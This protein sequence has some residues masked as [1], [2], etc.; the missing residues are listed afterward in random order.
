MGYSGV[1]PRRG[2]EGDPEHLVLIVVF[3]G[4]D[5]GAGFFVFK[6]PGVGAYFRYPFLLDEAVA[7]VVHY[8]L[9]RVLAG[10]G[11]NMSDNLIFSSKWRI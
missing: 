1:V 5:P 6:E 7:L 2:A 3:Y 10:L 11:L 9:L 4:Q 8:F